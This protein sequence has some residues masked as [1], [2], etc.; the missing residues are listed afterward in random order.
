MIKDRLKNIPL[1][2]AIAWLAVFALLTVAAAR[3]LRR[4]NAAA[5]KLDSLQSA[6]SLNT[7]EAAKLSE[8]IDA[9]DKD[10]SYLSKL[11]AMYP[12]NK[13]YFR[14]Q[15][16]IASEVIELRKKAA[17]KIGGRLYIAVDSKANKLYLKRGMRLLL[18]ADCSVG[19]GGVLKD[20]TTGRIWEF[21]TPR[22]EFTVRYKI[23]DPAWIKPDWAYVENH[24]P[25]PP[26]DDPSRKVRGELGKYALDIGNGYLIHGT[27]NE[28]GLGG[29][30]SHGCVRLGAETLEKLYKAAPVGTKVYIY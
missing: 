16:A 27:K 13:G 24:E 26:R 28:G 21:I 5:D 30:V 17:Q 7:E 10:L 18:E 19:K 3:N 6:M 2:T 8:E 1:Y 22:G 9:V 25:V 20:K 23:D 4:L 29:A 11:A 14:T 12:E 15:N